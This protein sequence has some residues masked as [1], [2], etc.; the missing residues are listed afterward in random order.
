MAG[1]AAVLADMH[2]LE[3]LA[4]QDTPLHRLDPRAKLLTT[5]VFVVCVASFGK[6]EVSALFPFAVFPAVLAVIGNLPLRPL[7]KRLLLLIPFPLMVGLFNPLID[8]EI[9]AQLGPLAI[10]GGWVSFASLFLR[11]LLTLSAA[12]VLVSL[13]GFPAICASL[14]RFGVPAVFVTQLL[15]L[16]RYIYVLVEEGG[17]MARA[18]EFRALG[19]KGMGLRPTA[20][21]LGTLLLRTWERAGR[22]HHAML[23]RGFR[24]EF[25]VRRGHAF[26]LREMLF[27][28]GWSA[29]FVALRMGN[30][31]RTVGE[32]V[33]E[34]VG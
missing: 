22:I 26:G 15:F 30:L 12:L 2:G 11:S 1:I 9:I 3:R 32:L 16:H 5:L 20:A 18:R 27:T 28:C 7:L 17:R 6:Y 34:I 23:C 19:R 33:M 24:G 13:T 8:R 14:Q 25:S 21:L 4:L 10:S 29:L 31:S